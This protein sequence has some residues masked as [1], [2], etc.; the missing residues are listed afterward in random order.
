MTDGPGITSLQ[1]RPVRAVRLVAALVE[2]GADAGRLAGG[3]DT[4]VLTVGS[5]AD[6]DLVLTDPTVSRY[7]LEVRH[8]T[9]GLVLVDLGSRNGTF[10][11]AVRVE[12]AVVAPG[13]RV[14]L[15]GS[16]V[17]VDD[18]GAGLA[19]APAAAAPLPGLIA[20]APAMREVAALASRLAAAT[21]S[22]LIEGETGVGKGVVARAIHDGGPR[23]AAPFVVVDCGSMPATLIAS[24]LFGH[25]RGA[26]TGADSRRLGAFERANG[27][28]VFLDELG[29]LPL[30][31]QPA[32][33]GVL[34]R[35]QFLRLGGTEPVEVD[36][37]IIAATHRD[38]RREVNAGTFR[39]DLYFR[40]AV[41][42]L[43]VP[44]LRERPADLE[45]LVLSLAERLGE[46]PG[47]NPLAAVMDTLRAQRWPGNVRELRNVVESALVLGVPSF[48][49]GADSSAAPPSAPSAAPPVAHDT[50]PS[51]RQAK[52]D[53]TAAFE[54]TYLTQLLA[55]AGGNVSAAAR[56]AQ[57][58]R[59][60]LI[61]LLRRH[62]LKA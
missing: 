45:P 30:E 26:F 7:H 34:E 20:H 17:V 36:V 29:E 2:S 58:D 18:G 9:D 56:L 25:D 10:V 19:P 43:L 46:P 51:Y 24:Q 21:T 40:L 33:L 35:R 39:A 31:L 5:A 13:T 52:A 49:G 57:M 47:H 16:T 62:D 48:D 37:R 11:G 3:A 23:R 53:A 6:C 60:Y 32:L 38:L 41:A 12:R 54:R 4:R 22:I 42:R 1:P 61:Q 8:G 55:R 27:G 44:P 14:R 50:L 59:P 15:G 28:T